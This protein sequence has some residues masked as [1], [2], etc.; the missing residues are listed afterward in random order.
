MSGSKTLKN[1]SAVALSVVLHGRK[2]ADPG[3]GSLPPVSGQ[4]PPN[5]QITLQYGND[6]NPYLNSMDV[7]EAS[8]GSD[9]R[10]TFA[11][12]SR[13]GPGTLDALFNTNSTLV[14]GFTPPS[15]SFGLS[16]HN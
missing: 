4:I 2:G 6:Q 11:A 10:Q 9:V 14:I 3:G 5:G 8:N 12:T 13:G 1:N 7:E 15:Y 16:A